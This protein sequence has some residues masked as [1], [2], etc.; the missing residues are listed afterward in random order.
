[1]QVSEI[2]KEHASSD[3]CMC[4]LRVVGMNGVCH[5]SAYHQRLCDCFL[6]GRRVVLISTETSQ[7]VLQQWRVSP[8]STRGAHLQARQTL[9]PGRYTAV[10]LRQ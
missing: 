1:M 8:L 4:Y 6:E 3:C 9:L 5:V 7:D 2:K 10:I